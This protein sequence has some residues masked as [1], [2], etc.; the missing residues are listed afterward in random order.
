MLHSISKLT[1]WFKSQIGVKEY[2]LGS[3]NVKY[4]TNYYGY[5]VFGSEYPWC[6]TFIWDG[7]SENGLSQA[8]LNG[9]KSAYCPYI[10]DWA[11]KNGAWITSDYKEGDILL[12]K[13]NSNIYDHIGYCAGV[14]NGTVI[15]IEGNYGDKVCL[16]RRD[17]NDVCGAYRPKYPKDEIEQP[18]NPPN[19]EPE[20]DN[21]IPVPSV[22]KNDIVSIVDGAT[23]YDGTT[24]PS[25][26][27][28]RNWIVRSVVGDRAVL[29]RDVEHKYNINSAI[30]S[31][32]LSLVLGYDEPE[33]PN[34]TEI[35]YIVKAGDTLW[36]IAEREYGSGIKYVDILLDN[37]LKTT[38]IHPGQKIKIYR[39]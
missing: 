4:N 29:G 39:K 12:Y 36:D 21:S 37:G 16:V 30:N 22:K 2:P 24:I 3:N 18:I 1:E 23:Y 13:L 31:R 8:Y 10:A 17:I 7:F 5:E 26:V 6:G 27:L 15:S 19:K 20:I 34:N 35:E 9:K 11:C 14:S 33:R 28:R 38:T 25:W 32:Y